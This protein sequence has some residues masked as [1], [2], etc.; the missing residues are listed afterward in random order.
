[1]NIE[2]RN[3]NNI[4]EGLISIKKGCLN[5]K[6]AVNG[7][8]KSTISNA[9]Y[10]KVNN[11]ISLLNKLRPYKYLADSEETHSPF[12]SGLDDISNLMIFNEKYVDQ[13]VFTSDEVVK[14]SFSIFVKT[15]KYDEHMSKIQELLKSVNQIFSVHPEL[16]SLIDTLYSFID[17][18]GK[19]KSGYAASGAIGKAFGKGNKIKNIPSGLE[20]YTPFIQKSDDGTNVKWLKWQLD[21]KNYLDISDKCP[22]CTSPIESNKD[23]ILKLSTEYNSKAVEHLDKLLEIFEHLMPYFDTDTQTNIKEIRDNIS[24]ITKAQQNYLVEIKN[25]VESFLQALIELKNMSFNSLKKADTIVDELNKHKINLTLFSHLNSSET[26]EKVNIISQSLDS[27]LRLAGQLQGEI[28]QQKITLKTTIETNKQSINDFLKCAGY[29]YEVDIVESEKEEYKM[30]LKPAGLND[31]PIASGKD[32][33]SYGERNAF[34]LIM[35]MFSALKENPDL[36]ILDD[37]ISSFDGNKKFAI[38]SSLFLTDKSLKNKTVILLTHEFST[39]ID[40]IYTLKRK[41]HKVP[42]AFFLTTKSKK[43]TEKE[44]KKE[45]IISCLENS[46]RN[47]DESDNNLNKIIFLRRL[48]EIQDDKSEAYEIISNILHKRQTPICIENDNERNMTE[49]EILK[50]IQEIK[51]YIPDFDYQTEFTKTQDNHILLVLYNTAK[52]NY[53]KLQLYRIIKNTNSNNLVVKKFVNE[54]FHIE[55][56]YLFQLNPREYDT[57]PKYIID[58]CD[59]DLAEIVSNYN[60]QEPNQ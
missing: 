36:I 43:L 53:E 50:G 15:P 57:V 46:K 40:S 27:V 33:L 58:E 12:I 24:G 55:N 13:F 17:G 52:S 26:Q 31:V 32:H 34:S 44:I 22:Y 51:K 21:G 3:C 29:S 47:I 2:I 4:D 5:I 60:I 35:F 38:I 56:D 6:Y 20:D 41:F 49:E 39:V 1:M 14:D 48:L 28:N 8:G 18:F 7:T 11:D 45:N 10:A 37:P 54:T 9:I 23:K 16:D 59:K 25:Q 30:I 42:N 19:S